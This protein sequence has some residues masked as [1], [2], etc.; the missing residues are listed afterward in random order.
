MKKKLSPK[1]QPTPLLGVLTTASTRAALSHFKPLD[2]VD[3]VHDDDII[4][5]GIKAFDNRGFKRGE[6]ITIGAMSG[7]GQ[8]LTSGTL[9]LS[10]EKLPRGK[11]QRAHHARMMQGRA[12][13]NVRLLQESLQRILGPDSD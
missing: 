9:D 8:S 2:I 13:K 5:T 1:L 6:L 7:A 10:G 3:E 12:K 4:P 11:K